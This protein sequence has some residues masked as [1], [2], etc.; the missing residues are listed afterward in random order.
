MVAAV[1]EVPGELAD[2]PSVEIVLGGVVQDASV[3]A[4][5]LSLV[6]T[7][8]LQIN[9]RLNYNLSTTLTMVIPICFLSR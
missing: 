1:E 2:G 6:V 5:G 7:T 8:D 9:R 3:A 4:K